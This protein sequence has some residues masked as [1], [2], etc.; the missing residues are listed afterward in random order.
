MAAEAVEA[1]L[2][3]KKSNKHKTK[4]SK[5]LKQQLEELLIYNSDFDNS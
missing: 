1:A 2:K 3:N 4:P 5:E